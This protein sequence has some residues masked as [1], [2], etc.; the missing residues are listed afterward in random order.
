MFDMLCMSVSDSLV[1]YELC[2][3]M[4]LSLRHVSPEDSLHLS[5]GTIKNPRLIDASHHLTAVTTTPDSMMHMLSS[6]L[7]L[8]FLDDLGE[9]ADSLGTCE[10]LGDG[11]GDGLGTWNPERLG[12]CHRCPM[13]V[14]ALLVSQNNDQQ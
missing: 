11:L 1:L 2:K 6:T 14:H 13:L 4:S 8:L 12:V 9:T 5:I 3:N 10:G 7:G